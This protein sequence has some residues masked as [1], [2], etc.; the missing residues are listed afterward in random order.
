MV[1][2]CNDQEVLT[3]TGL[4]FLVCSESDSLSPGPVSSEHVVYMRTW[5][6]TPSSPTPRFLE[7]CEFSL[8]IVVYFSWYEGIPTEQW[9][10]SVLDSLVLF[11]TY[12]GGDTTLRFN[13]SQGTR[14]HREIR[15][16]T[17][18]VFFMFCWTDNVRAK[19]KTYMLVSVPWETRKQNWGIYMSRIHW[20][21]RGDW[22]TSR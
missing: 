8:P 22:N 6:V 9:W 10:V 15:E 17:G 2:R 1:D 5:S 4:I 11:D 14:V 18:S 16:W 20:V 12:P 7:V 21:T 19:E 3:S 13:G